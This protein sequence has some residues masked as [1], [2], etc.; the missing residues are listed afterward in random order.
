MFNALYCAVIFD[1]TKNLK[2][3][4]FLETKTAVK[5]EQGGG[6]G[7]RGWKEREREEGAAAA[8]TSEVDASRDTR[9]RATG[10]EE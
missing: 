7:R 3:V 10:R 4:K 2:N 8:A 9:E 5:G 1:V 6:G